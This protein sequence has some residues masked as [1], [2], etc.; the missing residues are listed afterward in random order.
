MLSIITRQGVLE[1]KEESGGIALPR[2]VGER[3]QEPHVAQAPLQ[4]KPPPFKRA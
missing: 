2:F 4:T 1:E 3:V